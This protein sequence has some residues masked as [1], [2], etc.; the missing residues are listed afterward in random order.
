[1][2]VLNTLLCF[3]VFVNTSTHACARLFHTEE[4]CVQEGVTLQYFVP[5]ADYKILNA[6]TCYLIL[7]T[8]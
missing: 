7:Y 6:H 4:H 1:M 3:G 8:M 2:V 5:N